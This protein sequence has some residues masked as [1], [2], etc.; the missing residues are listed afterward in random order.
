M[1]YGLAGASVH[2]S[3]A[4][5]FWNLGSRRVA[6]DLRGSFPALLGVSPLWVKIV[7]E[8]FVTNVDLV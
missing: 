4:S 7:F 1:R 2:F 5:S 3:L 8:Y 6:F